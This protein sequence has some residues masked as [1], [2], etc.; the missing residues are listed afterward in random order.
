MP[1]VWKAAME[2]CYSCAP[3]YKKRGWEKSERGRR[4]EKVQH[5]IEVIK[6]RSRKSGESGQQLCEQQVTRIV[7]QLLQQRPYLP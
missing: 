7:S 1:K 3:V 2:P 5:K 4:T 6:D